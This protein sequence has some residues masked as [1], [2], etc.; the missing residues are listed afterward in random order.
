MR[1][2]LW[3]D[4]PVNHYAPPSRKRLK[5]EYGDFQ[6]PFKLAEQVCDL[7]VRR[8]FEPATI[9]EPTCGTGS[10]LAAALRKFP[11]SRKLMG[12]DI[13]PDHIKKA[14]QICSC[15]R[16]SG[17]IQLESADFFAV[18]WGEVLACLP[19]PLLIVGNPPWVTSAALGSMGSS[20]LPPKSNIH[21][22][23]G[24]DAVTGKSN[25]DVSEWMLLNYVDW[26]E[27]KNG[28]L[29]VLCKTSV[30]RK[31]ILHMWEKRRRI[32]DAHIYRISAAKYFGAAV[33][34]CLLIIDSTQN[35]AI[36]ECAVFDDLH[37]RRAVQYLGFEKAT[38]VS[39]IKAYDRWKH[40]EGAE[41]RKWRSGIKHNCR[42]IME[43]VKKDG[44]YHN[45][46][47]ECVDLENKYLYPMMKGTEIA[48][49][50]SHQERWMLVPQTAVGENT[51]SIEQKAPSTWA[52]LKNH[53]ER[54]S[55]RLGSG[56]SKM[57]PFSIFGV[58]EYSFSTWKVA[59][60]GFHK[61]LE[62]RL[63]GPI[64]GKP[65]ML[66]DAT[67]F[68][69]CGNRREAEFTHFLLSTDQARDFLCSLIFWDSKRPI[70]ASILNR[71]D[72]RALSAEIS[73]NGDNKSSGRPI[74]RI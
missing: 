35:A 36:R 71:L 6:T 73:R 28:L 57:V 33:Q 42:K 63:V 5:A 13:N 43:F 54:L 14:G 46:L 15:E 70:T 62:F 48:L 60:S 49:G 69:S 37:S 16:F 59:I 17:D 9:L 56:L 50:K 32:F 26:L 45:G 66:D 53:E 7:I 72:L 4:S 41:R 22:L 11:F 18:N 52:Y 8:G 1:T 2:G 10:F 58:G 61:R 24:I 51:A 3:M 68:I 20:N 34:A 67:Y 39:D 64:Q 44:F 74:I 30:A 40:L 25:F 19:E 47:G 21:A 12:L 65:V 23:K 55:Q 38:L 27:G 29:A 31:V